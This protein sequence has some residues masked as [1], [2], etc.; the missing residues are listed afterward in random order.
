MV[1]TDYWN[2]MRRDLLP[3]HSH[4]VFRRVRQIRGV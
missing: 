4:D 3:R 2:V 1:H